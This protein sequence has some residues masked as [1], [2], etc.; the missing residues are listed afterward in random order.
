MQTGKRK[1]EAGKTCLQ[2]KTRD[3]TG[4]LVGQRG[5]VEARDRPRGHT[6]LSS[7][8]GDTVAAVHPIGEK[9]KWKKRRLVS[10]SQR[11][12]LGDP[13][14]HSKPWDEMVCLIIGAEEGDW[15]GG[16]GWPLNWGLGLARD[17]FQRVINARLG[18]FAI[19][20]FLCVYLSISSR[21]LSSFYPS[22]FIYQSCVFLSFIYSLIYHFLVSVI[23]T[24]LSIYQYNNLCEPS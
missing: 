17:G 24:L 9:N 2:R 23:F 8:R 6:T 20:L 3:W 5:R 7:G 18:F 4:L 16:W 21:S 12:N 22:A 11:G 15:L 14:S 1:R 10:V 19:S 13:E